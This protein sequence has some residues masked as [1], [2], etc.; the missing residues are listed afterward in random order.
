MWRKG[1]ISR[2]LNQAG[3]E[4]GTT[5][6]IEFG[7]GV[8]E[9][10][11][12]L[13]RDA[14]F[15]RNL[16]V[17]VR[18]FLRPDCR[19]VVTAKQSQE[20]AFHGVA[21]E[22]LLGCDAA[23]GVDAKVDSRLLPNLECRPDIGLQVRFQFTAG[24]SG[25]PDESLELLQTGCLHVLIHEFKNVSSHLCLSELGSRFRIRL[26]EPVGMFGSG[27]CA[28][29]PK[30]SGSR[31]KAGVLGQ[32]FAGGLQLGLIPMLAEKFRQ[33]ATYEGKHHV[34]DEM[35]RGG[36]TLDIEQDTASSEP[37]YSFTTGSSPAARGR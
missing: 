5:G 20:V 18:L 32:S 13:G 23:G 24:E 6:R 15:G 19:I 10:Q 9:E 34:V 30:P 1:S 2:P 27:F 25:L 3:L 29:L 14:K 21:E 22:E 8:T 26:G 11:E 31:D 36:R 33:F 12:L 35:N 28:G 16:A 37:H 4:A 17:T 7:D